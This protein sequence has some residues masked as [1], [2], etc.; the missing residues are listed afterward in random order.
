[1]SK[2]TRILITKKVLVKRIEAD[3]WITRRK[4]S[5]ALQRKFGKRYMW[6]KFPQEYYIRLERH[7]TEDHHLALRRERT[8]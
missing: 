4:K 8:L 5:G 6:E 1:M 2:R 7:S 3:R